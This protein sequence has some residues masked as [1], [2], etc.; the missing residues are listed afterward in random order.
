MVKQDLPNK[1]DPDDLLPHQYSVWLYRQ[2]IPS[3][4]FIEDIAE[5]MEKP[6]IVND[7]DEIID[8]VRRWLAGLVLGWETIEVIKKSYS[9]VEAEKQAILRHNDDRDET[10]SQKMRV[11]LVYEKVVAPIL[12]KRMKEGKSLDE[13][14]DPLLESSEGDTTDAIVADRVGWG[15]TKYWQAKKIWEAKE[16]GDSEAGGVTSNLDDGEVSVN[17]AY[18]TLNESDED[19]D[20]DD[21]APTNMG[22]L[23]GEGI[24]LEEIEFNIVNE[25]QAAVVVSC[26]KLLRLFRKIRLPSELRNTQ[27]IH[28]RF[29]EHE[30][31][32][33]TTGR[34]LAFRTTNET[35]IV[36]SE[37][38]IH[39]DFFRKFTMARQNSVG[40]SVMMD[41]VIEY[42]DKFAGGRVRLQFHAE[43]NE[44]LASAILIT[45]GG[46]QT[47]L[48]S[49]M[50]W[51][52][53]SPHSFESTEEF[54]RHE[55]PVWIPEYKQLADRENKEL[56]EFIL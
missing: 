28:L 29:S 55:L 49:P 46:V 54:L 51:E 9:S 44:Q 7:D 15:E 14:D 43:S 3:Q 11:A 41:K 32:I 26:D 27:F 13:Q 42:L 47:H 39:S 6:L 30:M 10:F 50:R 23:V 24:P 17:K 18:E 31:S 37:Y 25:E 45:D 56:A 4:R 8:G 53:P 40:I 20:D 1:V 5:T 12:E 48:K 2:R 35:S 21:L 38:S 22:T 34:Q 52:N 19:E 16:S 33:E 36:R